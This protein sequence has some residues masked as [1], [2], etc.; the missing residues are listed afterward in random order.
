MAERPKHDDPEVVAKTLLD[1]HADFLKEAV[2]MVAAQLMEAEIAEEIGA[3]R[4]ERSA[5]S[6]NAPKRLPA[7]SL[8]DP[9]RRDRA[10][11]AAKAR[12]APP[13]SRASSSPAAPAS[14]RSSPRDGGL[15]ERGLDPQGR[16]PRRAA[17]DPR[18]EQGPRLG[19]LP[20][21]RRAGRGLPRPT[22]GGR[23]SP[24]SGSTPSI[25]R[26]EIAATCCSKALVVAYGVHETGRREVIGIS[27]RRGRVGGRSGSSFCARAAS[28]A[29]SPGSASAISDDH[30]GLKAA[31]ARMLACPWQRCTVHFVRNMLRPLP[32][33]SSAAWSPPPCGRSST[34][35]ARRRPRQRAGEV[36]E[37]FARAR[38]PKVAELPR[39]GRGGPA[40]LLSLPRAALAEA[41]LDQPAGAGQ[42]RDR[43]AEATSSGSSPMTPLR[44]GSPAPCLIEQNDEWLVGRRYLSEES[45]ALVLEDQGDEGREV[46]AELQAA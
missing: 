39:G 35:R 7:A 46:V 41:A 21:P 20:G 15:R 18:D 17:R 6:A 5:D 34:P 19:A 22:A 27:H 28:G 38:S 30:E 13:T 31:I 24:T 40:R 10:R 23:A 12:R 42:P 8:G 1:E 29:A 32:A 37:R 26:S 44:S 11:R 16:P 36:I 45:L 25:S 3:A 33:G 14:R 2:A 43:A 4:G 9:G